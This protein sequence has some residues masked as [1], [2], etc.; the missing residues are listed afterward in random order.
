[1]GD[2]GAFAWSPAFAEPQG[3]PV[4]AD[5]QGSLTAGLALLESGGKVET[6]F[7]TTSHLRERNAVGGVLVA[8][9]PDS[10]AIEA[11]FDPSTLPSPGIGGMT[12]PILD[13]DGVVYVGIR[14]KHPGV[15]DLGV[16]AH[17]YAVKLA[18]PSA[19]AAPIWDYTVNAQLDWAPPVIGANG[20]LYFGSTAEV[21]IGAYIQWL[22]MTSI[23]PN[24]SPNFYAVFH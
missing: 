17:V 3:Y 23:A 24:T 9:D 18:S 8:I 14:G 4:T 1:M 5:Q 13:A 11:T 10:G 21:Q 12:A 7:A 20:G 16:D 6:L 15:V 19:F 2:H 22:D